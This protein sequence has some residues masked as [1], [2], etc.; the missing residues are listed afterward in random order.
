MAMRVPELV[1]Y[2][3]DNF[4]S[5]QHRRLTATKI[6]QFLS[7]EQHFPVI[8]ATRQVSASTAELNVW[9]IE[10]LLVHISFRVPAPK[11]NQSKP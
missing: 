5:Q 2:F 1:E 10:G 4:K 6:E 11:I 9:T 3:F 8:F 7:S